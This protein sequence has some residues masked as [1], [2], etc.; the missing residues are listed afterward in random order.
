MFGAVLDGIVRTPLLLS[1]ALHPD[2]LGARL[3]LWSPHMDPDFGISG[4]KTV[5]L[6]CV[7]FST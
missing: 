3:S 2:V 4:A 6:S 1:A 5:V 7:V